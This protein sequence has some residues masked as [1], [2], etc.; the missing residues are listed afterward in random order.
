MRVSTR[1]RVTSTFL[2]GFCL[3]LMNLGGAHTDVWPDFSVQRDRTGP[4]SLQLL[5]DPDAASPGGRVHCA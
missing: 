2:F 4:G 5:D 3:K 1:L